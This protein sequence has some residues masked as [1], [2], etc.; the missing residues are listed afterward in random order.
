MSR[1]SRGKFAMLAANSFRP[2]VQRIA[3]S[4]ALSERLKKSVS[5][6]LAPFGL[7]GV[8]AAGANLG[9]RI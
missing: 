4:T 2:C 5:P 7:V 9:G 8:L 6:R 3:N 1:N